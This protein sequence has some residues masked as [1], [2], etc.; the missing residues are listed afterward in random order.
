MI[1]KKSSSVFTELTFPENRESGG[2]GLGLS[3]SKRIIEAFGGC[4]GAFN[5]SPKG[6]SVWFE[7]PIQ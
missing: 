7:L 2:R 5:N 6:L 1:L 3:I 4:V